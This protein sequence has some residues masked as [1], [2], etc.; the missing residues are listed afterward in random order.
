MGGMVVQWLPLSSQSNKVVGLSVW[1]LL[2]L[3]F[4]CMFA[5]PVWVLFTYSGFLRQNAF[6]FGL[7]NL[8]IRHSAECWRCNDHCAHRTIYFPANPLIFSGLS[9]HFSDGVIYYLLTWLPEWQLFTLM[10]CPIYWQEELR[11]NVKHQVLDQFPHLQKHPL[12][13]EASSAVM[14]FFWGG[15]ALLTCMRVY[16]WTLMVWNRGRVF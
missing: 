8:S 5:V 1:T 12:E 10:V 2:M 13:L 4:L 6:G 11:H 16:K 9:V 14:F 7:F 3:M 15:G